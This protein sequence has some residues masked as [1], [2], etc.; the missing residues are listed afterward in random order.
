MRKT[1]LR[2]V[3]DARRRELAAYSKRIKVWRKGRVCERCRKKARRIECHHFRGRIGRLLMYEH[4]WFAL[5]RM[6]HRWVHMNKDEAR[7]NMLLCEKPD[8]NVFP[9][10]K[11]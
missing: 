2:P 11:D 4:F 6:C 8:W 5:C 3:S 1:R 10:S 9:E 7:A